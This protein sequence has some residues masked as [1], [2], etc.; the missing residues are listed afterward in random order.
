MSSEFGGL[1]LMGTNARMAEWEAAILSA[2]IKRLDEQI[3]R[4]MENASTS[5][6]N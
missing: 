5:I 3:E 1:I 4:R 2:Q 6:Q